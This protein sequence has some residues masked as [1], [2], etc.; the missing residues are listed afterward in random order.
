[1][2]EWKTRFWDT[3]DGRLKAS[4]HA[5]ME[6]HLATCAACSVR[7]NEFRAGRRFAR[8]IAD[9]RTFSGV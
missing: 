9:D 8:R 7:V 6:K 4:E 2:D 1:V 5:E 3:I